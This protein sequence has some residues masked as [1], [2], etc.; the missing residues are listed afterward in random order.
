MKRL[1]RSIDV[2]S[3]LVIVVFVGWIGLN[4]VPASLWLE[5]R[6]VGVED[7]TYGQPIIMH[8]D[9]HVYR[10]F[11]GE[12]NVELRRVASR[13]VACNGINAIEY[14][15]DAMLP[16]PL[17]FKWWAYGLPGCDYPIAAGQYFIVTCWNIF[18]HIPLLS[19]RRLCIDSNNFEVHAADAPQS[20][21]MDGKLQQYVTR[22]L[23]T[24]V[25]GLQRQVRSLQTQIVRQ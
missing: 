14:D 5:V 21:A 4:L 16:D 18:H 8:V 7:S 19:P 13:E 20:Q 25:R 1:V 3:M 12:Y 15:A 10:P 2:F 17:T 11:E 6:S 9:R 23:Q 22:E 24:K